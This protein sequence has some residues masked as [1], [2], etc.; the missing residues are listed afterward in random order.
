[1]RGKSWAYCEEWITVGWLDGRQRG[2]AGCPPVATCTF[3]PRWVNSSPD[4]ESLETT[5]NEVS[6]PS[7]GSTSSR[8]TLSISVP[9]WTTS[10][11]KRAHQRRYSSFS[12]RDGRKV[13]WLVN[14]LCC[15]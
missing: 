8:A 2:F 14:L 6:A 5:R 4:M 3:L 1:M 15:F 7:T 9:Y 13:L 11:K 10:S 12:D